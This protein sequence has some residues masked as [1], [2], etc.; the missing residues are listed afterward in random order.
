MN[1]KSFRAVS[2]IYILCMISSCNRLANQPEQA[3]ALPKPSSP[4]MR[5]SNNALVRES[6]YSALR[7]CFPTEDG[8]YLNADIQTLLSRAKRLFNDMSLAEIESP[9]SGGRSALLPPA[10]AD[11]SGIVVPYAISDSVENPVMVAGFGYGFNT[12]NPV[13][14]GT[15]GF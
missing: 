6:F 13:H 15:S 14:L 7:P 9:Q 1:I 10:P 8:T 5:I 11:D 12:I 2:F 4:P 3:I